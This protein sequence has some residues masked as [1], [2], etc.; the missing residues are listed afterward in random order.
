AE[1]Q[2]RVEDQGDMNGDAAGPEI[3]ASPPLEAM[4]LQPPLHAEEIDQ[5]ADQDD[6]QHGG[7]HR[8]PHGRAA[9]LEL[10]AEEGAGEESAENVG[11]KIRARQRALDRIYQ[12]E[13]VEI[14]YEGEDR[15]HA[16][17]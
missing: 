12:V 3:H 15:D 5:D 10:E 7:R 11:G 14:G 6:D 16:E 4:P 2:D 17:R 8:R 9:D 13:G 1:R